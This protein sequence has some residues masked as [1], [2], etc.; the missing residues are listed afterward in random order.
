MKTPAKI[1]NED[2]LSAILENLAEGVVACD[3]NGI[4]TT[5]NRAT[6]EFHGIPEKAIPPQQWPEH[7]G[8]YRPDGKALMNFEEVPLYRAFKGEKIK[9]VEMVIGENGDRRTV[10]CSGE[11]IYDKDGNK[12][13]AVVAMHDV[14]EA[15]HVSELL[16]GEK[17]FRALFEQSPLSVQLLSVDGRTLQVN[18]AWKNLWGFSEEVVQNF[19]LNEYN[20]LEDPQLKERGIMSVIEEGFAGKAS[21]IPAI[22]YDTNELG[23]T[24]HA[25]W[26]EGFI[27][28]IFDKEGKVR[29]VVIIHQD[30]TDKIET[31]LEMK[32]AREAAEEAN[33]LKSAFLANMSHE[34]RTPLGA[35]LGF[36][37]LLRQS[38]L[39]HKEADQY[40]EIIDRSGKA[41][42]KIIDDILDLSKVEAGRLRVE[43]TSVNLKF[44]I[45][46]VISLL[47]IEAN[48]RGL[49]IALQ[50]I[51]VSLYRIHSDPIR[52]RQILINLIGNAVK[53]TEKGSIVV[54]CDYVDAAQKSFKVSITDSG[55]GID[56]EMQSLLFQPF[57]QID[58]SR[59]RRFGGS[60]LGLALSKRLAQALQG[61]IVLE[62]SALKQGSTF[63]I[64]LPV[65]EAKPISEVN[66]P[67]MTSAATLNLDFN[68][69]RVLV[70][71]DARDNRTLVVHLL[72]KRGAIVEE[73]ENGKDAVEKALNGDFDI[74]LMDIQM[75][76]M[77]GFEAIETLRAKNYQGPI[78]ALTAHA[79]AEDRV[80]SLKA[81]ANAHHVKPL[82]IPEL[83]QAIRELIRR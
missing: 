7:Y 68:G 33:R 21:K 19:I 46:E 52:L 31:E 60:G 2:F 48:K 58:D 83:M 22:L 47:N 59:T 9:D 17:R 15:R 10:V 78:I 41:L 74:I 69:I 66:A 30:V 26:V 23:H 40:L 51:P 79:M 45:E 44:L 61:D 70:V 25:R 54:N 57:Q 67:V 37:E 29:E 76:V 62:R 14:S 55:E 8:L 72:T 81:G 73:V 11:A 80:R 18:Q 53:F 50:N 20:L 27:N 24:G 5:F 34:I 16:K 77:D 65:I 35:I 6:R 71:D 75:P 28:P 12:L 38:K 32:A 42:T 82:Q 36:T 64:I 49:S 13:G 1:S 4:L 39:D 56:P 63:S 3:A 43:P